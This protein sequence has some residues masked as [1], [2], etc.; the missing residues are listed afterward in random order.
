VKKIIGL[1]CVLSALSLSALANEHG[2]ESEGVGSG[3]HGTNFFPKKQADP[4]QSTRPGMV[5]YLEP[6]P[7]AEIAA[8][9]NVTLKWKEV[10]GA[11]SYRVQIATDGNFKFL[12]SSTDF[13]TGNS[14]EASGLEAGKSYFWRVFALKPTNIAGY[15][16]SFA[17]FSSFSVK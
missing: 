5:E 9:S 2:E 17:K 11:D 16:S 13:V 3:H 14:F 1:V 8:G 7:L 12:V 15:T 6:K 10:V 4:S